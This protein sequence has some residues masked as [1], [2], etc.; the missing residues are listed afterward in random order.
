MEIES[1]IKLTWGLKCSVL[2]SAAERSELE[3]V[4]RCKNDVCVG[5]LSVNFTMLYFV[6]FVLHF[7]V[8][9]TRVLLSSRVSL[10]VINLLTI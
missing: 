2:E 3:V 4:L 7:T 8:G 10:L 6:W 5:V 9:F 1:E